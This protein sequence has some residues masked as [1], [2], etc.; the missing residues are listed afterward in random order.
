[1]TSLLQSVVK[2]GTGRR[3]LVLERGDLAGKTGTTNEFKDAWFSGFNGDVVTTTWIGFDQPASMGRGEAGASAALPIWIDYM[4]V[5]LD[6]RPETP[7]SQPETVIKRL[8]NQETGEPTTES[9]PDAMEEYFVAETLDQQAPA[10]EDG[11]AVPTPG[12]GN[13]NTD[14]AAE[15]GAAPDGEKETGTAPPKLAPGQVPD[16]LEQIF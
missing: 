12:N 16:G 1:M 11:V 2:E 4:K 7:Y 5:A 3:A 8:V 9:D 14:L 15:P 6:G 13:S 10:T